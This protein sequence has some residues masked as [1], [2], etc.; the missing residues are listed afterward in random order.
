VPPTD[1]ARATGFV[2]SPAASAPSPAPPPA[3]PPTGGRWWQRRQQASTAEPAASLDPEHILKGLARQDPLGCFFCGRPLGPR[4]VEIATVP[5]AGLPVRPLVCPRHGAALAAGDRP[6]VRARLVA[7]HEVA[8]FQDPQFN[9]GWDYN[10]NDSGPT[11]AWDALPPPDALLEPAPAVIVH[12][13]DPRWPERS[14]NA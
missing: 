13:D 12:A 3:A 4:D 6:D 8:W 5:L 2:P 10:P 14:A 1:T 7:G 11:V 9:P